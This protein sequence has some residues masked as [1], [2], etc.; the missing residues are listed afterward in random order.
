MLDQSAT[1]SP[2]SQVDQPRGFNNDTA[3]QEK[4]LDSILPLRRWDKFSCQARPI[5]AIV[6]HHSKSSEAKLVAIG[7]RSDE[8]D[9]YSKG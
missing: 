3:I 9:E 5:R 2:R 1:A 6:R 7:S 4:R 8:S